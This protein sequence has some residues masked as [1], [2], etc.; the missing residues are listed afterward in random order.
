L[1]VRILTT[2]LICAILALIAWQ[3][4]PASPEARIARAMLGERWYRL[5]LEARHLGYWHTRNYRDADGNWIFES[6]QRFALGASD[7]VANTARRVFG[8]GPPHPLLAAEHL[9][10]RGDVPHGVRIVARP[11]G[12]A[13]VAVPADGTAERPL[14]W[15]YDLADYLEF[16]LWLDKEQPGERARKSVDTLDFERSARVARAFE[17]VARTDDGYVIENAAPYSAT[18][19]ELDPQYVPRHLVISGLFDLARTT[20]Q[21]AL[22]P[23]SA[24]QAAS[25]RIPTDR[26]LTD[27]TRISRLVIGVH[28]ADDPR[29]LFRHLEADADGW[30]LVLNAPPVVG[31]PVQRAQTQDSLQFPSTHPQI[32]ALAGSA[33]TGIRSETERAVALTE[34][35]HAFIE[36]EPRVTSRDVLD[37]LDDPRGDCTEFADLLTTL[38]R[39]QGIPATTVF[40]LAYADGPEP[41]FAYHAWNELYVDGA[42]L[43]VDPTWGELRVD[44]THIPLPEDETAALALL[45]GSLPL[46]FS[47]LEVERFPD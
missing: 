5:S 22:E 33:V 26:R 13:A 24:L 39:S 25:Y 32:A 12:Y 3:L 37:L 23:R 10:T 9:Q 11:G 40:G 31:G 36:Y 46:E 19:I 30:R 42:W 41:A 47:I 1:P 2:S 16:E 8:A 29:K 7:P 35:V 21:A 43:A 27:H 17:V 4:Q 15:Q 18:R 45:T 20:R 6:E 44:A 38:A 14:N 28:G 34:L